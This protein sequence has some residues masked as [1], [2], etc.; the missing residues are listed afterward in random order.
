MKCEKCGVEID[1][2]IISVFDTYGADYPISVDVEECEHNAV[3]LETDKNWTG[4]ELDGDEA[5]KDIHCPIC[6]SNPFKNDEIQIYD[7]VRIVKFESN[8]SE[9]REITEENKDENTN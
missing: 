1:H 6:G 3:V 2:L 5:N 4:Y 8:L 9:N 7:V